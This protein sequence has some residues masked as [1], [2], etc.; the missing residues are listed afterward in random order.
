MGRFPPG[1]VS[2]VFDSI[3]RIS[4]MSRGENRRGVEAGPVTVAAGAT[5]LNPAS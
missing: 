5:R 1:G 4:E 3:G 2:M